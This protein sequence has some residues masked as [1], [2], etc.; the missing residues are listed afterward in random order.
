MPVRTKRLVAGGPSSTGNEQTLYT[1]GTGET[2]IVKDVWLYAGAAVSSA[3]LFLQSSGGARI[4][5]YQ[6]SLAV[7]QIVHIPTWTVLQAGD[8][9]RGFAAGNTWTCWVSGAELE[10]VAD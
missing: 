8:M 3:V 1:A 5:M 2:V 6:S 4:S 9:I 7:A 10:G